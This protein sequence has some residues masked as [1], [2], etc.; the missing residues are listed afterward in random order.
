[1]PFGIKGQ[2]GPGMKQVVGFRDLCK[3]G[4]RLAA[5]LGCAIVISGDLL[6]Q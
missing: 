3:E 1:M 6:S 2:A 5:N 4:V